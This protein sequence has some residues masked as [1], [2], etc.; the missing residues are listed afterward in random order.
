MI[1]QN[2]RRVLVN[3]SRVK[4]A[5]AERVTGRI[6]ELVSN[7]VEIVKSPQFNITKVNHSNPQRTYKKV[8][9][10]FYNPS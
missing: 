5:A 4:I 2:H 7:F 1:F 8:L 6:L 9:I 3:V 10:S